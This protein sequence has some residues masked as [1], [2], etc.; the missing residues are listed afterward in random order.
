MPTKTAKTTSKTYKN[1]SGG[2]RSVDPE[3]FVKTWQSAK[4]V[5]EVAESL[6]ADLRGVSAM[7]SYYRKKGVALKRFRNGVAVN[8]EALNSLISQEN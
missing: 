6:E 5:A 7:A 2:I 8:V 3:K 1:G 4:N